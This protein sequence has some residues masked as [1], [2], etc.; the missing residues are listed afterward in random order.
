MF[1]NIYTKEVDEHEKLKIILTKITIYQGQ[2]A[3]K[4]I[5]N[6]DFK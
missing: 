6:E 2:K 1:K 3:N 4:N 5:L